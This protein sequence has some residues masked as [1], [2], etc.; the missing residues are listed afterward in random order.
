M[1]CYTKY[2]LEIENT[3]EKTSVDLNLIIPQIRRTYS[4]AFNSF[5]KDGF[6]QNESKWYFVND[7]LCEFSLKYPT[8]LFKLYGYEEEIDDIWIRYYLNGKMVHKLATIVY[9]PFNPDELI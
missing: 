5:N 7:D 8:I 3:D 1:G 9:P 2:C 4:S 6:F